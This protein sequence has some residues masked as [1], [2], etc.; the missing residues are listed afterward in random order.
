MRTRYALRAL[1]HIANE[2]SPE[3][4]VSAAAIAEAQ[5][6]SLKFLEAILHDLKSYHFVESRK[7][8]G[9]GYYLKLSPH[10]IRLA[11]VIRSINGPIALVPCVSL[12]FYE[13]CTICPDESKCSLH[14][15]M[16]EVRDASLAIL[17]STS[18][19]DLVSREK[20]TR[21]KKA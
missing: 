6:V 7:G 10:E 11:D 2:G 12:N 15:I 9:G 14:H 3:K 16:L 13:A 19:A 1:I 8:I 18:L 17:E 20:K 5:P 4:P 21:Q